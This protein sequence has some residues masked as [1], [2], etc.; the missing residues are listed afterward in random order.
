[1]TG[2]GPIAVAMSGG[3]DSSV[4]AVRLVEAGQPVFGLM[5]RLWSAP[6]VT[7]RCCSPA[8]VDRARRVARDLEIP[9]YVLDAQQPFRQSVVR[10]FLDGYA[11][12][13]TPN[14]CIE[15]NRQIRWSY[16]LRAALAMGA[17]RLATGHYARLKETDE[18]PILR[19]AV[20]RTKDQSYVLGMLG[21]HELSLSCFPLGSLTKTEVRAQARQQGLAVADR[22]E[23]QDLCFLGGRDYREVLRELDG[24]SLRPGPILDVAGSPMGEHQG[25]AAYT[26]GQR[27]GIGVAGPQAYYV[28]EKDLARN[29]LIVGP[30]ASLGRTELRTGPANWVAGKPPS[31][32]QE[33]EVQIRYRAPARPATVSLTESGGMCITLQEPAVDVTPGQY[34]MLY[35]GDRCFGGGMILP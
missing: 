13:L 18:G 1:M 24:S 30:R 26:I 28:I 12:G 27:K 7:N 2:D 15:C 4:A 21:G 23:S 25:L 34:A 16:L 8:D 20:D 32:P 9:F 29:A 6:G 3:V 5:L 33:L 14:P 11:H 31:L 22:A 17:S 35:D 19:R 10:V